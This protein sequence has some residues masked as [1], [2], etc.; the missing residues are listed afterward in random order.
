MSVLSL[1]GVRGRPTTSPADRVVRDSRV[2]LAA[3]VAVV[4]VAAWGLTQGVPVVVLLGVAAVP[5]VLALGYRY[6]FGALAAVVVLRPLVDGAGLPGV[7]PALGLAVVLVAL[8]VALHDARALLLLVAL[9]VPLALATWNGQ[10]AYGA[11]AIEEGVRR[12]SAVAVAA[13]VLVAPV[14]MTRARAARLVQV[15]GVVPAAVALLQAVT[16]T[17]TTIGDVVR[18]QG[19]LSQANPAAFVFAV[20]AFASAVLVLEGGPH[21]RLDLAAVGYFSVAVVT[22]GSITGLLALVL[23]LTVHTVVAHGLSSRFSWAA[24]GGVAVLVVAALL[25]PLGQG[26]IAEYTA[27]QGPVQEESSLA[28][29]FN[30]WN[31]VIAAW[32]ERPVE[33]LGLGAAQPGGILTDNIPHNEYLQALAET[34]LIGLLLFLTG[35]VLVLVA[36]AVLHRRGASRLNV[37]LVVALVVG[38]AVHASASNTFHA[39]PS[40]FLVVTLLAAALRV[41]AQEAR[42]AARTVGAQ[43]AA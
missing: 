17:G 43:V 4:V 2:L 21:R 38:V 16:G 37:A 6:A 18:S 26:R 11:V 23:L 15:A 42:A 12:F 3:A 20:C 9:A 34:G 27:T 13:V 7:N 19:T 33:G 35:V 5:A 24:M 28:W 36:V 40:L 22:T 31:R 1:S 8:V 30:A 41:A 29:R 32:R 14:R 10:Q 25:S 39:T